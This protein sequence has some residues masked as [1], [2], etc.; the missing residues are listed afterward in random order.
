[1]GRAPRGQGSPHGER[2]GHGGG[3]APRG[4]H[5]GVDRDRLQTGAAKVLP[6]RAAAAAQAKMAEPGSGDGGT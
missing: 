4:G 1:M 5:G 2:G 3:T 6:D